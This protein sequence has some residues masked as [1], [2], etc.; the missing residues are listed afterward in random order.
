LRIADFGLRI[1]NK[2][3]IRE[4]MTSTSAWRILAL[5]VFI[6]G[7]F[8]AEGLSFPVMEKDDRNKEIVLSTRPLRIISLAPTNTELLFALGL[9]K[10]IVGVTQYCNYPEAARK[11]EKVGGFINFDLERI[12]ALQP[13]L[14]LAFGTMQLPVVEAMEKSG[15]RVFW[16]YPH[17]VDDILASFERVG[18]LTGAV[19]EARQLRAAVEKEVIDLRKEFSALPESKRPTVLRVMSLNQPA[20]IGAESFQTDLFRLAGGRNAFPAAGQD[21]FELDAQELIM[22]DPAVVLVCGNDEK[23]L[24]QKI[25]GSPLYGNL[26]AV[27]KDAVLVMPCELTCRPGPRIAETARR[28]ARYLHG[29]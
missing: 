2:K 11:K 20:T 26:P 16:I 17:T 18:R 10:E 28:L 8:C 27:K 22:G 24:K 25:K 4:W 12:R 5:V 6:L 19:Q 3:L 14:I 29:K 9:D 21:Y 13:D 23:S 7:S 15:F 1:N